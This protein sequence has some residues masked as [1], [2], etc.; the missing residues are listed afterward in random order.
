MAGGY[1]YGNGNAPSVPQA[2]GFDPLSFGLNLGG[3]ALG[4]VGDLIFGDPE[5]ERQKKNRKLLT[6]YLDR[7]EAGELSPSFEDYTSQI[8]GAARGDIAKMGA[9]V[10]KKFGLDS[11]AGQGELFNQFAESIMDKSLQ[12]QLETNR[13]KSNTRNYLLSL[14]AQT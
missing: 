1:G 14:I 6:S 3:Q 7:N 10:D 4:V 9:G 5:A 2:P 11:G 8:L 13:M 12:V